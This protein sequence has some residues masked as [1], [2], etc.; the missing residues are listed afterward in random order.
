MQNKKLGIMLDCSRNAVLK[1]EKAK[2]FAKLISEMGYNMMMLYT[3]DTYEV[4][5]E[6]FFGHM[7]GRYSKQELRDMDEYCQSVGIELIP[8]IQT[9][10]HLSQLKQWERY[11]YMYDCHDIL[12]VGQ[13]DV[14]ELIEKMF[15]TLSECMTSRH[16]HVGMD[17]AHFLGRGKYQDKYGCRD[18]I[19]ILTEH[20]TRVKEI[21]DKYGFQ[22]MIWSDMF[23][24]LHNNGEYY[25]KNIKIPGKTIDMVPEGVEL[26]YWDYYTEEKEQ[27]DSMFQ[28]H[29][30]FQNPICFAGGLWT[31]TGYVPNMSMTWERLIPSMQS[32]QEHSIDTVFFTM[33]GDNGKDCSFYTQLPMIYAAAR[34]TQGEFDRKVI[35]REFQEKYGYEFDEF[36]NLELPNLISGELGLE[37]NP[38]KYLLFNDPFIGKFDFRVRD[39][40]KNYYQQVSETLSKSINGRPY[41]YL[42]F[43]EKKLSEVLEYKAELGV[44]IRKAY[45]SDDRSTLTE[46]TEHDLPILQQRMEEFIEAFRK[47]WL[48]ENKAFG[49][50]VQEIRLG[51]LL[52][53]LK[54]CQKRLA[55]YLND[56]VTVIEELQENALNPCKEFNTHNDWSSIV[57]ASVN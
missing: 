27:Y 41:D 25:G 22:M 45:Q 44:R 56:E 29:L 46:I 6:P 36:M 57:T 3:E 14:Y 35:A 52:Y 54:T 5:E 7:R 50:E 16:I 40:L 24:R 13:E 17:E 18:R 4:D 11:V 39:G 21:A 43:M 19:E 33:W 55:E 30:E 23:I 47:M 1:P 12:M 34:M 31:W 48:T 2:E 42:F 15:R 8:C 37:D 53:R 38:N 28:T 10:A 51:A 49:L 20:L 32:V 26:V 9:L